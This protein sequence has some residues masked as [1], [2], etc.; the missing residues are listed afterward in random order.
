LEGDLSQHALAQRQQQQIK[1]SHPE[2]LRRHK[3]WCEVWCNTL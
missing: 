3:S 2:T 1:P